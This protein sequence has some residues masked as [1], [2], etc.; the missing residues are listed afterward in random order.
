VLGYVGG[1]SNLFRVDVSKDFSFRYWIENWGYQGEGRVSVS[2]FDNLLS[3]LKQNNSEDILDSKVMLR[4]ATVKTPEYEGISQDPLYSKWKDIKND[5]ESVSYEYREKTYYDLTFHIGTGGEDT[6]WAKIGGTRISDLGGITTDDFIGGYAYLHVGSY[7]GSMMLRS[8]VRQDFGFSIADGIANGSI[9]ADKDGSIAFRDK[10]VLTAAANEGYI[11]KSITIGDEVLEA[12]ETGT[13]VY[14]KG[15]GD[16]IASAEF[17]KA[18]KMSFV[19]NGGGKVDDRFTYEG[20]VFSKPINPKREGY[21]FDG[22]FT[23]E[24]CTEKYD[25]KT[26]ATTD[27]TLYALWT[28]TDETNGGAEGCGGCKSI[29]TAGGAGAI[30]LGLTGLAFIGFKRKRK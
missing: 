17:A 3:S 7:G 23:D 5:S 18:I 20:G 24:A 16:E 21:K 8:L 9:S 6:S 12:D 13:V 30:I 29:A 22:W 4:T 28:S 2:L 1:I 14:Y 25:W 10:I 26:T 15:W 19:P 11:L 27:I